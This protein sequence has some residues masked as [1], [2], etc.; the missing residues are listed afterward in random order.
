MIFTGTFNW[1][2]DFEFFI[3]SS[4][5]FLID[6]RETIKV[7]L[8]LDLVFVIPAYIIQDAS[9]AEANAAVKVFGPTV[10]IIMC[11]F[12]LLFNVRKHESLNKVTK[13]VKNMVIQDL[14][15]EIIKAIFIHLIRIAL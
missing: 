12:H 6:I 14:T 3:G 11:W 2:I 5:C 13:E 9:H 7:C 10:K 4:N 1:L 15:R 8:K